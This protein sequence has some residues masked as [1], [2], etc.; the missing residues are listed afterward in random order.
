MIEKG[1][2]T[3]YQPYGEVSGGG[4]NNGAIHFRLP[5]SGTSTHKSINPSILKIIT[6]SGEFEYDGS[7][8]ITVNISNSY[9]AGADVLTGDPRLGLSGGAI[10][11]NSVV[12]NGSDDI[13][14]IVDKLDAGYISLGTLSVEHGGTGKA[15]WTA[16]GLLYASSA[17]VLGQ[18]A[19]GNIGQI[20]Q[21]SSS[22]PN[23]VDTSTLSVGSAAVAETLQ[24]GNLGLGNGYGR[25]STS[26]STSAKIV[27]MTGYE[28]VEGGIVAVAFDQEVGA[29]ATLNIN[30]RGA[31]PIYYHGSTLGANI[32]HANDIA[33]F[34]YTSGQYQL[35]MCNSWNNIARANGVSF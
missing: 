20:L 13:T 25:C 17:T 22:G 28:L 18:I 11:T 12:F 30:S 5:L 1:S 14:L 6:S 15:S 23:W 9:V 26:A 32:I 8:S 19:V 7:N 21:Q 27:S 33:V 10:T 2:K 24:N 16:G 31:K 29:N 3:S 34:M 35:L 4:G